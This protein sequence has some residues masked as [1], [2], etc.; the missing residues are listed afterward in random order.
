MMMGGYTDAFYI[1]LIKNVRAY[2]GLEAEKIDSGEKTMD[3]NGS[4]SQ[5]DDVSVVYRDIG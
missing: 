2:K 5:W 3:V 1:Q 4:P